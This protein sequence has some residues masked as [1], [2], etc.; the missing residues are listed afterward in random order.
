MLARMPCAPPATVVNGHPRWAGAYFHGGRQP[1]AYINRGYTHT[2]SNGRMIDGE[3]YC[4]QE[5]VSQCYK[6]MV[7]NGCP[8]PSLL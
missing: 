2:Y 6:D 5:K 1:N 8:A 3:T 4:A 7:F